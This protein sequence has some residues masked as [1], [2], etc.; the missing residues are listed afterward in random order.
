AQNLAM[1]RQQVATTTADAISGP[2][3]SIRRDVASLKE[4]QASVD[5]RTQ[6]TF[7]AVY[8]TIERIVDRLAAIEEELQER[9]SGS[10]AG[11]SK[12]SSRQTPPTDDADRS[13]PP[14]VQSDP[15]PARDAPNLTQIQ[16]PVVLVPTD[17]AGGTVILRRPAV[18]PNMISDA[19]S[20]REG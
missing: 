8:G 20:T 6:D 4:I 9:S 16:A 10:P 2:A 13:G 3:E 19:V 14:G 17:D 18:L 7:E 11:P 15:A 1:L 12:A 5:R